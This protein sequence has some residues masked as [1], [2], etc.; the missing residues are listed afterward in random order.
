MKEFQDFQVSFQ[1]EEFCKG[2]DEQLSNPIPKKVVEWE[3]AFDR[4]NRCKNKENR[5]LEDYIEINIGTKEE[6]R[7]IKIGKGTSEKERKNLVELVKEIR[8]VFA[9]TYDELKSY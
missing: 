2:K 1:E 4:K 5:K 7:K 8:D 6:P 9:F 3:K